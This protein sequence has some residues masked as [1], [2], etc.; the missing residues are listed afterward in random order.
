M[1]RYRRDLSAFPA[2]AGFL[3]PDP[4]R[5]AYWREQLA[6]LGG[7]PAVGIVWKSLLNDS[8]RRRFFSP[9]EQWRPI[10]GTPGVR[11]VNLQYGDCRAEIAEARARLGV[12]IWTPPGID[13]KN[14]LDD[15][16]ALSAAVDLVIG[17]ANAATNIAAAVGA[18]VWFISVPAAWPRLG[19]ETYPWYPQTRTFLPAA[20]NNWTPVM[21][22]IA[23]ALAERVA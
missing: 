13:L 20:Y 14:D 5:V 9:F 8:G 15:V 22:E 6:A 10:L 4:A 18:P 16:A 2:E 23:A 17:P 21:A 12:E 1:R 19:A 3:K 7:E 11:F